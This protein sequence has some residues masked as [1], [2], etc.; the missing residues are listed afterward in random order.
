VTIDDD[1]PGIAPR[2]V[3]AALERGARLSRDTPGSGLGLAIAADLAAL[4]GGSLEL[5]PSPMGGLRA[6][7][8]LPAA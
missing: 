2:E 3:G 8:M 1:G 7:L 5:Q 4:Y 6:L